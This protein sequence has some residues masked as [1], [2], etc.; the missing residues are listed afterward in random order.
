[1]AAQTSIVPT[2]AELLQAQ[3][4]L[5]RHSLYYLTPMALRCAVEL[6]IPTV[7]HRLG[8]AA[9]PSDL[10]TALSLPSSKLPFLRRL[11]RLL[12]A[13]GVFSVDKSM[14]GMYCINPVSYLLVE[15]IPNEV[16]INHT[17]LVL[18]NTSTRYIDAAMG[19]AEWFKRDVVTPPFD[20][21]HGATLLHESMESLD[22]DYHK[23]VNEALQ[24]HDNFGIPIAI[25]ELRDLFKGVQSMTYCCGASG[26]DEFARAIV[27]AF[28]QIKCTV[29][30]YPKM[31]S[32]KPADS[33]I[34]YVQGDMFHFIPPAQT[35]MLKLVL[36]HWTDEDCVMILAQCRKAIPSRKDG[37]KVIIG[38]IVID[39][40]PGPMLETHLLMDVAMMTMT[41]G[42]QRDEKE[43]REI[44]MKAGF[45]DYKLKK[46]F[47]A[48]GVFE[49]YP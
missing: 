14:E 9:S 5:W 47:G 7:I 8:G 45:S 18:A 1:M 49:V 34:N 40:F 2:D 37:G 4:D 48:R 39:Y 36:H 11:L 13:E 35:V 19:L 21:V 28:P 3:A 25:R 42:R 17:S 16:H 20:E 29:L 41:K 23:M 31:I 32:N 27:K 46:K 44:F 38:D 30:A 15:G 43:W 6:G 24:A 10:I 26:D 12:A 22:A 33:V